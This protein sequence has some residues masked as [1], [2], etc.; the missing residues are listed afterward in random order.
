MKRISDL[1]PA[2]QA[3]SPKP[4]SKHNMECKFRRQKRPGE[5]VLK[6]NYLRDTLTLGLN[7][8]LGSYF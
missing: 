6:V 2:V 1:S 5:N 4:S 8:L 3:L 7:R